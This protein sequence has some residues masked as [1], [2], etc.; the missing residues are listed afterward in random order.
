MAPGLGIQSATTCDLGLC[1]AKTDHL[2][3][4]RLIDSS[5][6]SDTGFESWLVGVGALLSQ[7]WSVC[8]A[9]SM[10]DLSAATESCS[11]TKADSIPV[12]EMY[13]SLP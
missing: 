6:I 12:S 1:S 11:L 4:P 13:Q 8:A 3:I 5:Y 7:C 10:M 9:R 2:L